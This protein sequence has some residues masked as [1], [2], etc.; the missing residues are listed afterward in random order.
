[1]LLWDCSKHR[2]LN[3]MQRILINMVTNFFIAKKQ[4]FT[5]IQKMRIN[6]KLKRETNMKLMDLLWREKLL[7]KNDESKIFNQPSESQ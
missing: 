5:I 4:G 2:I 7:L 6:S 3:I 1:M